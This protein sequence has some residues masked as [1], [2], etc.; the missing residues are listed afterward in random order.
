MTLNFKGE[1]AVF[2]PADLKRH[3]ASQK[4]AFLMHSF[5]MQT[6]GGR[7][8]V[9]FSLLGKFCGE[10]GFRT[11]LQLPS[12][13]DDCIVGGKR[14]LPCTLASGCKKAYMCNHCGPIYRTGEGSPNNCT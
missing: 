10:C 1:L 2:N 8:V 12:A 9:T 3:V 11:E 7:G 6:N 5:Q 14:T 4:R 13:S